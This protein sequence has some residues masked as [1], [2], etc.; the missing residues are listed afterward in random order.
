MVDFTMLSIVMG[1]LASVVTIFAFYKQF[2]SKPNQELENLRVHFLAARS[3]ALEL[4]E[5]L[6]NYAQVNNAG[7]RLLMTGITFNGYIKLLDASLEN[8]LSVEK[9]EAIAPEL[10]KP[11]IESLTKSVET[12][13]ISLKELNFMADELI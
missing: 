7:D 13:L 10:K 2:Y 8:D 3:S 5:K 1:I 12:Q 11:M 4:R 6:Q 9:F